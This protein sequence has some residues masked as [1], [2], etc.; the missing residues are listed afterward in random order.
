MRKKRQ[1][2]GG[3][4]GRETGEVR[5]GRGREGRKDWILRGSS[6]VCNSITGAGIHK[7]GSNFKSDWTLYSQCKPYHNY[8]SKSH[9]L[10]RGGEK[11]EVHIRYIIITVK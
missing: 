7:P 11:T 1:G 2:K 6:E 8:V 10:R 9:I 3:E 5:E 4:G